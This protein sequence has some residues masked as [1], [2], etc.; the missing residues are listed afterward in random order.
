MFCMNLTNVSLKGTETVLAKLE[1]KLHL[2]GLK[3]IQVPDMQKLQPNYDRKWFIQDLL[4]KALVDK[5]D[6]LIKITKNSSKS[7][8][9]NVQSMCLCFLKI[10]KFLKLPPKAPSRTSRGLTDWFLKLFNR[11]QLV[12][13]MNLQQ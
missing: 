11:H 1:V 10:T 7:T 5:T 3:L 6:E 13:S 12:F 8:K 9:D 4:D 2:E